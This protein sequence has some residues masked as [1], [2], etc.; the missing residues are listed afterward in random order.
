M[1]SYGALLNRTSCGVGNV[2]LLKLA[3]AK[4]QYQETVPEAQTLR[5]PENT[6]SVVWLDTYENTLFKNAFSYLYNNV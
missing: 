3:T 5:R 6:T 1:G 2:L 4:R